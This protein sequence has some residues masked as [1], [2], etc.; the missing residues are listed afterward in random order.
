MR[1]KEANCELHFL[2]DICYN[3]KGR[4]TDPTETL[5]YHL[6]TVTSLAHLSV[7]YTS[8]IIKCRRQQGILQ[9]EK[10]VGLS[11]DVFLVFEK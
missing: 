6:A 9:A 10:A 1:S 7:A 3:F 2:R 8:F 4:K 5:S 11:C